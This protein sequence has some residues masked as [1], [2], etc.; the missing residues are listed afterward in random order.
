MLWNTSKMLLERD[1]VDM[2]TTCPAAVF[3][4]TKRKNVFLEIL[5]RC[6]ML[7][8]QAYIAKIAFILDLAALETGVF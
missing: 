4:C 8:L 2:I 5:L 3:Y 7:F 6:H 1:N